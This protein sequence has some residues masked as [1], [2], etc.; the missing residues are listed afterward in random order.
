MVKPA[1]QPKTGDK[2]SAQ[3]QNGDKTR[4]TERETLIMNYLSAHQ[5]A[6]SGDI[7]QLLHL[8]ASQTRSVLRQMIDD[9]LLAAH[10]ANRNRTYSL[11]Q[12]KEE[13]S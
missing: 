4:G 10:G 5:R 9:G 1:N 3:S 12:R 6:T 8:K 7:A 2:L 11:K 13:E